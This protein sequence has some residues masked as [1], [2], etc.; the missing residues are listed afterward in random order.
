MID[1]L[2]QSNLN[3]KFI[4]INFKEYPFQLKFNQEEDLQSIF[5]FITENL[6]TQDLCSKQKIDN[7]VKTFN[8]SLIELNN[9][10]NLE[11]IFRKPIIFE[12]LYEEKT[13]FKVYE[14]NQFKK[15]L[16]KLEKYYYFFVNEDYNVIDNIIK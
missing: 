14:P 11:Y 13:A 4:E 7:Y 16:F 12:I 10:D 8:D 15:V 6:E 3:V 2:E 9:I 1:I 5:D